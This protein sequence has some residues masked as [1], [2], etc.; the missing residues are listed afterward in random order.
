MKRKGIGFSRTLQLTELPVE[1][2]TTSDGNKQMN[3]YESRMSQFGVSVVQQLAEEKY[4][5]RRRFELSSFA[6]NNM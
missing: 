4:Y 1:L 3:Y 5:G 2:Q 6:L